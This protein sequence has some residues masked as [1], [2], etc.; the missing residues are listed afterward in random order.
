[1]TTTLAKREKIFIERLKKVKIAGEYRDLYETHLAA[2]CDLSIAHGDGA[3]RLF[4]FN[5]KTDITTEDRIVAGDTAY[6]LESIA[7]F[8]GQEETVV[9]ARRNDFETNYRHLQNL[10]F[11]EWGQVEILTKDDDAE[12]WMDS[13]VG[14]FITNIVSHYPAIRNGRHIGEFYQQFDHTVPVAC[15][16][17]GP[18]L[19]K[20]AHLLRD[21]PGLIIVADKAYKMLLARGIEPDLVISVDCH[22]DLVADMLNV[23]KLSRRHKLI[24]NTCADPK[25]A[26][27]WRGQIFWYL[28]KHPGVQFTDKILPALFPQFHGL[29]NVGCVGNTSMLFADF[30][31]L[32]PVVLVGQDFAY[33]GGRMFAQRFSFGEDGAPQEI[34]DDHEKLL[35][36]RTGKILLNGV[37]T[38][39]PFR[40]YMETAYRLREKA[41]INIIN[42]TEGGILTELPNKTLA[43]V[44]EELSVAS[45]G[46]FKT[47]REIIQSI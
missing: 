6:D 17:A 10:G 26:K 14:T 28:M 22:Y 12:R 31:G 23:G 16:G 19:D 27:I 43:Q 13:W 20:N 1:M 25:I 38:Y 44:I 5:G 39:L 47:A 30:M 15:V 32:S 29:S 36:D 33:T 3:E 37:E 45:N 8:P 40:G 42:C 21:F 18:S 11:A 24:L 41:G 46:K 34:Q 2:E 35:A 7:F 9:R 4:T